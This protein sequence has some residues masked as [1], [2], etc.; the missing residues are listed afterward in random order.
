MVLL[1]IYS[2]VVKMHDI[3]LHRFVIYFL[4]RLFT[5]DVTVE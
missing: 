2:F 5:S 3:L 1:V 4:H